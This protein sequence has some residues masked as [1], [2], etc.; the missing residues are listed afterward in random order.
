M[1]SQSIQSAVLYPPL[2]ARALSHHPFAYTHESYTRLTSWI[3]DARKSQYS[4]RSIHTACTDPHSFPKKRPCFI[5]EQP[6]RLG[7][8]RTFLHKHHS[9]AP[10]VLIPAFSGRAF[11]YTRHSGQTCFHFSNLFLCS[12]LTP[13]HRLCLNRKPASVYLDPDLAEGVHGAS[14][15]TRLHPTVVAGKNDIDSIEVRYQHHPASM[16]KRF[17]ETP[18]DAY[19]LTCLSQIRA[20]HLV[21]PELGRV[22]SAGLDA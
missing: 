14:S 7:E 10:A 1:L 11:R 12:P 17:S 13:S 8:R 9:G 3:E 16:G 5:P 22:R 21:A 18:Q 6:P 20:E 2:C 15:R 4:E 19:I